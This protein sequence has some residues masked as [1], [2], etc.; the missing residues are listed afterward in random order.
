MIVYLDLIYLMN[1]RAYLVVRR[2]YLFGE[3]FPLPPPDGLP[4][5]LGAFT[6]V[7]VLFPMCNS[8]IWIYTLL[9]IRIF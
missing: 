3:Q 5:V 8:F 4:V 2:D 7:H 1:R 9:S 6:G